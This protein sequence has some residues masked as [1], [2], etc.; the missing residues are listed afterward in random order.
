MHKEIILFTTHK[1]KDMSMNTVIENAFLKATIKEAGGELVSLVNKENGG[2]YLWQGDPTYWA[3]RSP[4]MFPICGRLPDGKY[5]YEGKEY[6]MN[7]HGFVK[8]STLT[9][10]SATE[11]QAVFL[12]TDNEETRKSYPFAFAYRII[13]T[14]DENRLTVTYR[15]ENKDDK[16][17]IFALGGHP[18]FNVPLEP[19]VNA[20]TY[21]FE[22]GEDLSPERMMCS[23][24]H[25]FVDYAPFKLREK[26]YLAFAHSMFDND[27]IFLKNAGTHVTLC[28][29]E[30]PRA[31]RVDFDDFTH[32]GLW[33][34]PKTD[35]P[36]VCIEPW[37]SVPALESET[38][39]LETKPSMNRLA[40]GKSMEKSFTI[41]VI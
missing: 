37:D 4:S 39:S 40:S 7:L 20:N 13:Y 9:V 15:V 28:S 29:V 19:G 8:I 17:L 26:K 27:A 22:Y 33:H 12:L 16:E 18:A 10:E 31:I 14:L 25:L 38:C 41:T 32:I 24:R 3:C 1:R 23:D 2:E 30:S 36:F 34:S 35:A 11:T 5:T 21:Y 6:E